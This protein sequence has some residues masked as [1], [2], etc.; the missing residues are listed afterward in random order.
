MAH[1]QYALICLDFL[2]FNV[3][4]DLDSHDYLF[5]LLV[6]QTENL[7]LILIMKIFDI[8]QESIFVLCFVCCFDEDVFG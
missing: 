2:P 6:W 3:F 4:K 5:L 7:F 1:V 8:A